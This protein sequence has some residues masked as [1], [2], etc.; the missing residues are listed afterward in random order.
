LAIVLEGSYAKWQ[1]GESA[2]PIHE[3]FGAQADT[4]LAGARELV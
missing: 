3:F 2:K 4:L 1:R